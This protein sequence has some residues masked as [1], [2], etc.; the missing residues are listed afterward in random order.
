MELTIHMRKRKTTMEM[1]YQK[2]QKAKEALANINKDKDKAVNGPKDRN[3]SP[4]HNGNSLPAGII[5]TTMKNGNDG[6][7]VTC[8]GIT[9]KEF[10]NQKQSL[11]ERLNMAKKYY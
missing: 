10:S 6:Y 2:L 1:N 9:R 5:Y 4:D 3:K 11:D 7:I 8:K